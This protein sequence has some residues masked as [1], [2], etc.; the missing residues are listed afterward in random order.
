MKR[1]TLGTG[2]LVA[3][4]LAFVAVTVLAN[5]GLRG[6]RLDLT[7]NRLYTVTDGTRSIVR[8]LKEPVN[9]H[10]YFSENA[11]ATLPAVRTYGI[12]VR[13]FLEDLAADSAGK[14]RLKVVDPQ[15]FSEDEDRAAEAGVRAV[16]LGATG[17]KLYLG[18]S[19]TN[20]TDGRATIEFFDPQK[21][22]FLEYDV[23]KL[24]YQLG[25]P[26]K[27]V[28]AWLS[29]L[30]MT[31]GFDP[32]SGQAAEPWLV[33]AQARELFELRNLEPA[34][35]RID[36]DVD[37]LVL[38]HPKNLSPAMQYAIDQFALRGGRIL[39]FVDPIAEGD[40]SG[41]EPGNPL[42]GLGADRSSQLDVLLRAWGVAFDPRQAV[43]DLEHGLTVSM[44]PGEA[45]SQHIGI[46][47]LD[48]RSMAASDVVTAS[49]TALN[50]ASSGWVAPLKGATTRFE[51]LVQTSARSGPL[52]AE[53]F[54]MLMDPGTLRDGF[55]PSGQRY[56][57]AARI[58]GPF[59]SAFPGG[60]PAGAVADPGAPALT[61]SAKPLALIVVADTDMLADFLWVR[62]QNLFGQRVAQPWANN[63][64]FVWNALDNL[65]GSGE[66]I[67]VR[68][69]A[70]FT[71]PF[72]RVEALRA[73]AED[74]F[75]AKEQE[76]EQQ[77]A[78]TERKLS[79]L[80]GARAD[81]SALILSPEQE[82]ELAQFQA[83][84]LRI[85]KDLRDVR[86]Q[87]DQDIRALG[88]RVKLF[89]VVLVP[90]AFA[91]FAL[92]I[93]SWRRRRQAAIV[94]LNRDKQ[95]TAGAADATG[96]AQAS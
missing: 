59:K 28:V 50:F 20:S 55:R 16:P 54:Q 79:E 95:R 12:R 72:D 42:G 9:L 23:A 71:R 43:G 36:S 74:R 60:P 29:S 58:T 83:E 91:A 81:Q 61:A 80:Q 34:A 88:N 73:S 69:R 40:A 38:V 33:Y 77:L 56:A 84:K 48:P 94:A 65:A 18:L 5:W 19:G 76:L 78:E 51:P 64:D 63:G 7:E 39:A 1:S 8:D 93:A 11:A 14:L 22:P 92:L 32:M 67:G 41:A 57:V 10:Y 6:L 96:G 4:A 13:E 82:K 85:R 75:R 15:P 70:T 66:L 68:G 17:D 46:L 87:L 52:P 25:N 89:N 27:P 90:L 45:P 31:G 26:K 53:R 62:Q 86:L 35:T 24:V 44:R 47:G 30:P 37:V 3:L 49:L 2:A 21:E